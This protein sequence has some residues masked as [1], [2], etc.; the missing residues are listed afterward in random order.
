MK[1][2]FI[3]ANQWL[4]RHPSQTK[5]KVVADTRNYLV[6]RFDFRTAEWKNKPVYALFTYNGK[7][8]KQTLGSGDRLELNECYIPPEVIHAPGFEMSLYC[9]NLITSSI[10]KV[11][12]EKSGFTTDI[13][14][15]DCGCSWGINQYE[16]LL[17]KYAL[18]CNQILQ[19]CTKIQ[20]TL[21]KERG[22][23]NAD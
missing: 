3:V 14:N 9:D 21:L 18:I 17:Q 19:D 1:L 12:V 13:E 15:A 5:L 2:D 16:A 6:A 11:D 22:E 7:T 20:E 8:Y 10:C 4:S 23:D